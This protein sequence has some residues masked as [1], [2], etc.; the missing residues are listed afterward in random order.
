MQICFGNYLLIF[1]VCF[2]FYRLYSYIQWVKLKKF[3]LKYL[4]LQKLIY[5]QQIF[6]FFGKCGLNIILLI[7]YYQKKR[8][9]IYYVQYIY[10]FNSYIIFCI[11]VEIKNVGVFLVIFLFEIC[12]ICQLI[13]DFVFFSGVFYRRMIDFNVVIDDYFLVMDKIDYEEFNSI[14]KEV[15]R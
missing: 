8:F 7:I 12:M 14:Y 6:M 11:F 10:L 3:F 9:C 1:L 5:Q 15:Y 2:C 4:L 13:V